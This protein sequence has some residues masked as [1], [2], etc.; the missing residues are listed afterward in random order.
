MRSFGTYLLFA[1]AW[2]LAGQSHGHAAVL[3]S[4]SVENRAPRYSVMVSGGAMMN[5]YHFR[6]SVIPAMRSHFENCR[7]IALVLHASHPSERDK[8]ELRLQKAFEHLN[9]SRAESLHHRDLAGQRSLLEQADAIFVGG[10]ET[11]VLLRELYQTGQL[12]IIKARIRAGV[13]YMGASAG[14]NVAGV[15]IGTTNDFPV[16]DVPSRESLGLIEATIN[17]HHPTRMTEAEFKGRAG[18]IRIYLSFN[19]NERVLG[20]G[21][22]ALVR[23]HRGRAT[24]VVGSAWLYDARGDRE[25]R[26]DEDIPELQPE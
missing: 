20:L 3:E 15:R 16:V 6:D 10:G 2:V 5:G 7:T 26:I 19:T 14:A 8:M 25:L 18:K 17:P 24:L 13:P 12:E 4:T 23:L 22:A 11:F 1:I 21:D 9:G